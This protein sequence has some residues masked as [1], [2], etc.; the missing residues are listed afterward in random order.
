MP[1]D[2]DKRLFT[3]RVMGRKRAKEMESLGRQERARQEQPAM[4]AAVDSA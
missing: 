2:K 3:L 4:P 1:A